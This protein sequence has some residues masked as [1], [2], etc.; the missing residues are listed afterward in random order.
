[1]QRNFNGCNFHIRSRENSF[2]GSPYYYPVPKSSPFSYEVSSDESNEVE[3]PLAD[4]GKIIFSYDECDA[5]SPSNWGKISENCLGYS[6]SPVNLH[7]YIA[8]PSAPGQPLII[9]GYDSIPSS[10]SVENSGH[11]AAF[12]FK[13]RN[14]KPVRFLGGPLKVAYILDNVHFHWGEDDHAGSEHLLNSRRYSAEVHLVTYN[15]KYGKTSFS[16][17]VCVII[18]LT[19]VLFQRPLKKHQLKAKVLQSSHSFMR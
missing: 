17:I 13:F 6:Q 15:S 16:Y 2:E 10:V 12:R 18:Q 4:G 11:S 3:T 8:K 7:T 14:D 19:P 1:M 9:D 5:Y